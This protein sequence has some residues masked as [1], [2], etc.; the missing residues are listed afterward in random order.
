M[1]MNL[2]MEIS[3]I[4]ILIVGFSV[5]YSM[6]KEAHKKHIKIFSVSFISGISLMLIWRTFHLFS[7]FN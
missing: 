3:V 5:A 7:Y 2:Y 4:L 6:L 1:K